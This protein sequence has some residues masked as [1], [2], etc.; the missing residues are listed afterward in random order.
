MGQEHSPFFSPKM[1]QATT[2][3]GQ[4]LLLMLIEWLEDIGVNCVSANTDSIDIIFNKDKEQQVRELM[5]KWTEMTNGITM[6]EDPILKSVY[7]NINAYFWKEPNG[8]IKE[9]GYLVT[10]YNSKGEWQPQSLQKGIGLPIVNIALREFFMNEEPI[11]N[12]ILHHKD[13]LDFCMAKRV[14]KSY[15]VLHNGK[16]QQQLNRYYASTNNGYLYKF[17]NNSYHH[18]LK[19]SGVTILNKVENRHPR[20]YQDLDYNY[21]IQETQKIIDSVIPKQMS[22]F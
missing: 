19:S 12:T 17:R 9:K 10:H 21:Y 22:L 6:G 15:I 16:K 13:I 11:E 3:N 14:D 4:L 20:Y 7:L 2:I 18:L 5:S 1:L 8:Y